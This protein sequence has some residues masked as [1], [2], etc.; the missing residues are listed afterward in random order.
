MH[1]SV[2]LLAVPMIL[3]S[4]ARELAAQA[5]DTAAAVA[6]LAEMDSACATR[7]PLWSVPLCGPTVLVDR[8]TRTAFSNRPDPAGSFMPRDG[9]F[10]GTLPAGLQVANTAVEWGDQRWAMVMVEALAEKPFER[11]RLLAHESFHRIQPALGL[12]VASPFAA[13]LEEESARLWL[14]MEL[15]ALARALTGESA[16]ARRAATDALLFRARRQR[17]H[18][19]ADSVERLLE[20]NEGVAEYTGYRFALDATGEG[21][22]RVARST[23]AFEGRPSYVR[24]LGYGTGP[25]LGLLLDR[26]AP[27]WRAEVLAGE[28]SVPALADRLAA[29][30]GPG[31]TDATEEAVRSRALAYGLRSVAAEERDRAAERSARLADYRRRLVEGPVLVIEGEGLRVA[32]NPNRVVPLGD[33]GVV[34]PMAMAMG[35][36]G[37]LRVEE[38]GVLVAPDSHRLHVPAPPAV[39]AASG[40]PV[41]GPG[42]VLELDPGWTVVAADR[43]GDLRVARQP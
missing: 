10:V 7:E 33:E 34:H 12:T 41:Q 43:P 1:R 2:I 23:E 28:D 5:V 29:A 35:E 17:L 36:W 8:A 27:G 15:R 39:E 31:S 3:A 18:P 14:R 4:G 6:A 40:E 9:A 37:T 42:W 20:A 24:S 16:E 32:F 38:G 22:G 13:H 19:G 25:G 26:F 30:L 21:P 11:L